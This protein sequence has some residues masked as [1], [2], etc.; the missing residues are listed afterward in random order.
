MISRLNQVVVLR[1]NQANNSVDDLKNIALS[2][3]IISILLMAC[4]IFFVVKPVVW[5]IDDNKLSILVLFTEIPR[6][7]LVTFKKKCDERLIR[8]IRARDDFL[9]A[10]FSIDDEFAEEENLNS[11]DQVVDVKAG[12][13]IDNTTQ[14]SSKASSIGSVDIEDRYIN[15]SRIGLF[16]VCTVVYFVVTYYVEYISLENFLLSVSHNIEYAE[17]GVIN[18]NLALSFLLKYGTQNVSSAFGS[19]PY[20][21]M[22]DNNSLLSKIQNYEK[23]GAILAYGDASLSVLK[24]SGIQVDY[25]FGNTCA[26]IGLFTPPP[27]ECN[28]FF[29][30]AA[31]HGIYNAMIQAV[32]LFK[33]KLL[34]INLAPN[35]TD[36]ST[37]YD[38]LNEE[39]MHHLQ[40]IT[41]SHINPLVSASISEYISELGNQISTANR[42][43][44]I[45]LIS[46]I[47]FAFFLY[48][49]YFIPLLWTLNNEQKRTI[50]LLF[51]IPCSVMEKMANIRAFVAK[52][53][54]ETQ[55][56]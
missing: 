31:A 33:L 53:A 44:L 56:D 1:I 7:Y 45:L 39:E 28:E 51:L 50:N 55:T 29:S 30:G 52:L 42:I 3:T 16:L 32:D 49:V 38:V 6:N 12:D 4:L 20:M 15:L 36:F 37:M 47:F 5:S 13:V 10:G 21:Y 9:N 17:N 41:I 35:I 14:K 25:Y 11:D 27:L 24:P 22:V 54:L 26:P 34:E 19:S 2:L 40:H 8:L 43:R 48:L 18:Q 23:I 46:F